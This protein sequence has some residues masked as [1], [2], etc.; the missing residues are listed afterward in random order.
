MRHVKHPLVID[1][2]TTGLIEKGKAPN[3]LC[4]GLHND[5]QNVCFEWDEGSANHLN[6]LLE[7]Y[8]PVFHNAS[9]DKAVLEAHGVSIDYHE[10]TMLMSYVLNPTAE[11]SLRSWGLVIGE[12]KGE[13]PWEGKKAPETFTEELRDYC[14]QD[15][16]STW[17]LYNHLLAELREDE[18]A[19]EFYHTIELPYTQVI[20][21]ME[22]A[23]M[24]VDSEAMEVLNDYLVLEM[25]RIRTECR[26]IAPLGPGPKSK[27]KKPA[28]AKVEPD[29]TFLGFEDACYVYQRNVPLNPGSG[30]H[31]AVSLNS[32]YGWTPTDFTPTGQAKVDNDVLEKLD[33]PLAQ[34]F[35]EYSKAQNV[36]SGFL[37]PFECHADENAFVHGNFNQCVTKTGRLSSSNPL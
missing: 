29:W 6:S 1:L 19:Y 9:F 26:E 23:G 8:Y 31:K 10:D 22:Q 24:H 4:V 18:A 27:L 37:T 21:E 11:H 28:D 13:K 12:L 7:S 32:V 14:L 20:L 15:V 35:I 17:K 3:I 36:V 16:K 34:K 25:D 2:E 30:V 33:Y 5:E